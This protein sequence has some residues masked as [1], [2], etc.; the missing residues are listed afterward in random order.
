MR[1]KLWLGVLALAVF[2]W[3]A[4]AAAVDAGPLL[5]VDVRRVRISL[6]FAGQQ[7]FI[8]GEVPEHTRRVVSV[9][10][11]PPAGPVRLMRKGRVGPFWLGVDQYAV[12]DVPGLY[13][14]NISCPGGNVTRPCPEKDPLALVENILERASITVGPAEIARRARIDVL[15]GKDTEAQRAD[16]LRGFW[17]LEESRGLYRVNG[18]GIFV[19]PDGKYFFRATVPASA[20]EATYSVTTYFL[21]DDSLIDAARVELYVCRQGLVAWLARLAERRAYLY[22]G[23]TVLIALAAGLFVGTIFR[24]GR[25]H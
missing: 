13:L 12:E 9:V 2:G 18:N 7:I 20:P 6:G 23:I 19:G 15:R 1:R 5:R 10:E 25:H 4:P 3:P 8:Y 17:I 24:R 11:A 14:V 16:L 22:G 21:G